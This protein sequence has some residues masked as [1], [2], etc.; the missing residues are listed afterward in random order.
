MVAVGRVC[1]VLDGVVNVELGVALTLIEVASVVEV[2]SDDEVS[3]DDVE[4]AVELSEEE[5]EVSLV[6]LA[7]RV[8]D[9]VELVFV[10]AF[11]FVAVP[12]TMVTGAVEKVPRPQSQS[13]RSPLKA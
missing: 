2:V 6:V 9:G 13:A 3:I 12:L 10:V 8:A 7:D 1:R 5:E 4:D 11:A